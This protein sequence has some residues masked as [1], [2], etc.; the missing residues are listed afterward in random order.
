[1]AGLRRLWIGVS[2]EGNLVGLWGFKPS[3]AEPFKWRAECLGPTNLIKLISTSAS[4]S[5]PLQA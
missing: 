1:M 4:I 2:H 3:N 5:A